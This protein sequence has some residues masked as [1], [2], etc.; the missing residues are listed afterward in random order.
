[1]HIVYCIGTIV[2]ENIVC[3]NV[4][5]RSLLFKTMRW[6]I[7]IDAYDVSRDVVDSIK[8]ELIFLRSLKLQTLN[9]GNK[10]VWGEDTLWRLIK[11][12]KELKSH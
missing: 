10:C 1:M 9:S 12:Y 11:S 6:Y 5:P 2:G 4:C 7:T 3:F 8:Y